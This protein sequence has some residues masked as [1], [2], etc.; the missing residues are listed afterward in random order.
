MKV[1]CVE[2]TYLIEDKEVQTAVKGSVY[3]V[4]DAVK[5]PKPRVK[6]D[7]R[8][9]EFAQGFWYRFAETGELWHHEERFKR[10]TETDTYFIR[11]NKTE[12]V[13]IVPQNRLY[14][15]T[16]QTKQRV[17]RSAEGTKKAGPRKRSNSI[18]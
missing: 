17:Q 10:L 3:T 14:V 6:P 13:R 7:G 12:P 8:I 18:S 1:I 11:T 9:V 15:E 16:K 4:I 5:N 2:D